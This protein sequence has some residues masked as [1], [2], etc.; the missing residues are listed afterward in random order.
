MAA[1]NNPIYTLTPNIDSA[2]AH[3]SGTVVGPSANTAQDGTG[4]N[5]YWIWQAGANGGFLDHVR[6]KS[7]VSP[8][9]TVARIYV[10][11]DT[12][13]SF[14]GGTTNTATNTWMVSEV[15]L[16][17]VTQSQTVQSPE[18]V[19]Q[20]QQAIPASYKVLV[21]FGTSTGSA[22]TGY[23]VVAFGGSY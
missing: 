5:T 21:S 4:A 13:G 12:S 11:S 16:L 15:S 18:F 9:A 10:C 6:F 17:A 2:A 1:N 20:L 8:A 19:W 3:N 22:G 23:S 7:I 14:T